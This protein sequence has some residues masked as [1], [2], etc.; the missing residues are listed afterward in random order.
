[1]VTINI[2]LAP[3]GTEPFPTP[4]QLTLRSVSAA[5]IAVGG[6]K[7][8]RGVCKSCSCLDEECHY[9]G[10]RKIVKL[11]VV[12]SSPDMFTVPVLNVTFLTLKNAV[13]PRRGPRKRRF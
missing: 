3:G 5:G 9:K 11:M 8:R 2:P 6:R 10:R 13:M 7:S 4:L 12:L 1:M